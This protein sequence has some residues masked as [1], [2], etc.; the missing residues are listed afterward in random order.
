M[1]SHEIDYEIIG[2]DIQLVEI[3]LDP[4]ETVIAEAGV[5]N[6][7]EADIE[8]SAKMG[9]GSTPNQGFFGKLM[10]AGKRMLTGESLFMTH[11]TNQGRQ[12]RK[13]GFAAPYPGKVVPFNLAEY[14]GQMLC[15]KGHSCA[16]LRHKVRIA[17]KKK[18]EVRLFG[19]EGSSSRSW[20]G[21]GWPSSTRAGRSSAET[22]GRRDSDG[23][24]L[25]GRDD[26]D[27]PLRHREAGSLKSMFFG[28]EGLFLAT[29]KARD[30]LDADAAVLPTGGP[31]DREFVGRQRELEGG[32]VLGGSGG[33]LAGIK[34]GA[35]VLR[36]GQR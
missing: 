23:H 20:R 5:M 11:F 14:D 22:C 34:G 4:G 19:G 10:G 12:K 35:G 15:E 30:G 32:S 21:T 29:W 28:G 17:F 3:E 16:R 36:P 31:A 13:V 2:D 33:C 9:D 27:R 24:R 8:F 1:K 6:Y 18:L 25:P 7:M 26:V